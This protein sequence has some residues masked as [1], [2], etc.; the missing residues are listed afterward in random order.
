MEDAYGL[1]DVID[2]AKT[3]L[4]AG[5]AVQALTMLQAHQVEGWNDGPFL[6]LLG[7]A[8]CLAQ[9]PEEALA[10]LERALD[11]SPS[12]CSHYNLGQCYQMLGRLEDAKGAYTHALG[13]DHTYGKAIEALTVLRDAQ[14]AHDDAVAAAQASSG[15]GL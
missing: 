3:A 6:T 7:V 9:Q 10:P 8:A 12:E 5:D 13:I 14:K 4:R 15:P 1:R 2:D 11:L